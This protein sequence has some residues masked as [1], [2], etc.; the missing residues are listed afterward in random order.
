[1]NARNIKNKLSSG[2]WLIKPERATQ[3]RSAI[4][5]NRKTCPPRRISLSNSFLT[6]LTLGVE[7]AD[8]IVY[9]VL[10][11]CGGITVIGAGTFISHFDEL[12]DR[13]GS[14]M[15]EQ[16]RD[17]IR[18]AGLEAPP[19]II[20]DGKIHRFSS[21][22]KRGDDAGWYVLHGDGIPAGSFGDWRTGISQSWRA[23]IGRTLS[24]AEESAHAGVKGQTLR[25]RLSFVA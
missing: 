13:K 4:A 17:V 3:I 21:N 24:P 7:K 12:S 23:D 14:A 5:E 10:C 25:T 18:A 22:G 2:L 20:A 1:V 19:N 15:I 16:F 11:I 6:R 8:T 9:P